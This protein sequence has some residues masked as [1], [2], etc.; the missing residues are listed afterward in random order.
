VLSAGRLIR[1]PGDCVKTGS[2]RLNHDEIRGSVSSQFYV[3]T[4]LAKVLVPAE[5]DIT[6][7]PDFSSTEYY[8]IWTN[9]QSVLANT[10][11]QPIRRVTEFVVS[12]KT[13]LIRTE[14]KSSVSGN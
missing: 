4:A 8:F 13:R 7:V 6:S 2:F 3:E 14:V 11:T 12:S 1:T 10:I 5:E 9:L